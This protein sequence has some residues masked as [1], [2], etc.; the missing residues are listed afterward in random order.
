MVSDWI[1]LYFA[2]VA[3]GAGKGLSKSE[4][5]QALATFDRELENLRSALEFGRLQEANEALELA[6]YLGMPPGNTAKR[7]RSARSAGE[8][9]SYDHWIEASSVRW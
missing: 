6:R 4:Q 3:V 8:S 5:G 1:P 9:W 2:D 7:Q